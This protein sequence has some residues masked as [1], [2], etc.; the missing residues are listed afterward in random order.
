MFLSLV[1]SP[2]VDP[3]SFVHG[4]RDPVCCVPH[5]QVSSV[6]HSTEGVSGRSTAVESLLGAMLLL[7]FLLRK[8]RRLRKPGRGSS[9]SEG[10]VS[11]GGPPPTFQSKSSK[12][13]QGE[14][15]ENSSA[16]DV[17][18]ESLC[19]PET[20]QDVDTVAGVNL[21]LPCLFSSLSPAF[22]CDLGLDLLLQHLPPLP[23]R[24]PLSWILKFWQCRSLQ[25]CLPRLSPP[26]VSWIVCSTFF[27][28][29]CLWRLCHP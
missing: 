20:L 24:H 17:A 27:H 11:T 15:M 19:A 14:G 4:V 10:A 29:R 26:L 13:A 7:T 22:S 12:A 28:Q 16:T 1:L 8:D 21:R 25:H 5:V 3:H 23:R 6:L 2:V 9:T 18:G